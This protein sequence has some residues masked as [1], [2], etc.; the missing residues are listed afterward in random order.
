MLIH[1]NIEATT[2]HN[3]HK[4]PVVVTAAFAYCE[5]ALNVNTLIMSS[6]KVHWEGF[7][8]VTLEHTMSSYSHHY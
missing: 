3:L 4:V 1:N 2:I 7:V 5:S 8:K 6:A